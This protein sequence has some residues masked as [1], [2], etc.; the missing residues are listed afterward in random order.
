MQCFGREASDRA[1]RLLDSKRVRIASDQQDTRDKYGR[2]L[3]YV[4]TQRACSTT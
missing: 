4:W 1:H 2:L 3:V